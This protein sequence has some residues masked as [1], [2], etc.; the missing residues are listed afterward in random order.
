MYTTETQL[1]KVMSLFSV[2]AILLACMGLFGLSSYMMQQ[3][4][5][6]IGIRKVLG[7]SLMNLLGILSGN[8]LVLV[9]IA[10]VIGSPLAYLIMKNWL[11]E[12]AYH[13]GIEWWIFAVAG[14]V[15]ISITLITVSIHGI[16]AMAENPVKSLRSE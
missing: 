6:E 13:T 10:I 5:K 16:R 4:M 15:I 11:S 9:I 1:G 14:L 12:F 3:R 8:F 2:T 7:A